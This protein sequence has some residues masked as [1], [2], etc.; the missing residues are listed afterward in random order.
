[1][2]I[3]ENYFVGVGFSKLK[4]RSHISFIISENEPLLC[5]AYYL[6]THTFVLVNS[7]HPQW[8]RIR[9]HVNPEDRHER[10]RGHAERGALPGARAGGRQRQRQPPRG[11]RAVPHQPYGNTVLTTIQIICWIIRILRGNFGLDFVWCLDTIGKATENSRKCEG[12]VVND[13]WSICTLLLHL[14]RVEILVLNWNI[15]ME[16]IRCY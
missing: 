13:K 4:N 3:V 10:V 6:S 9:R 16:K 7:F 11:P 12:R 2:K 8:N 15:I 1:M 14:Q 5:Q